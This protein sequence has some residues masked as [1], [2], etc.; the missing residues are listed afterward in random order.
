MCTSG[1]GERQE[2][3]EEVG[4]DGGAK[5]G[6]QDSLRF[7]VALGLVF[8]DVRPSPYVRPAFSS[9]ASM[10]CQ[11]SKSEYQNSLIAKLRLLTWVYTL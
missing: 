7:S 5:E 6:V 4:S 11:N 3:C 8:S 10:F 9:S 1:E 2:G